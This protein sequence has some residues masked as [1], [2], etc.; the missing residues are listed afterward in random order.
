VFPYLGLIL[1]PI[2]WLAGIYL[3]RNWHGTY[4]M[5]ISKHAASAKNAS[6]FFAVV[7]VGGGVLSYWWLIQWFTPHLGLGTIFV[8]L[9]SFTAIAQIVVAIIPDVLGWQH[10][11]HQKVA[12]IMAACYVPLTYLVLA[13]SKVSLSA[14]IIAYVC[15]AF[16]IVVGLLFFFVKKARSYYLVFQSLYIVAFQI[17]ILSSAYLKVQ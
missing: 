9:L 10:H 5:S 6:K 15:I 8:A 2:S 3:V 16:T 1:V 14:R 11:V 13:S 4:S 17:I 7:L 12:V